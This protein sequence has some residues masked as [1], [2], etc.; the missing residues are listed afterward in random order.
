[1]RVTEGSD[2]TALR[3]CPAAAL[4]LDGPAAERY[5]GAGKPFDWRR[6]AGVPKPV[7]LAGGLDAAN[8][9]EA[10][11]LAHPWGVDACSRV[12]SSPGKKDHQKMKEFL[13]AAKAA[14]EA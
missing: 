11:A 2:L 14:L 13:A 4:V 9:Q 8:V 1:V 5:G 12:E 6:A 10:I 7:I 3:N